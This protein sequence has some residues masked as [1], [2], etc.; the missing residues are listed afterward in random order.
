MSNICKFTAPASRDIESIIDLIADNSG[1]DAAERFLKKINDKCK[2]LANFP[3][4]GRKR[5]ELL[6]SLRSFPV[7]DYL[8]FYRQIPE[9]IEVV[10]VVSGY[11]D[12]ETL[13]S[14]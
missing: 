12:L 3:S 6:P 11:R 1:F 8:I 4:M 5:D 7:D 2:N 14:E 10:R 13:F 9:G